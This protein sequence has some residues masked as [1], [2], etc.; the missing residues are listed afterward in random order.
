MTAAF[1]KNAESL[2]LDLL[3]ISGPSGREEEV[4]QFI[5]RQ[6][7]EAGAPEAAIRFDAAPSATGGVRKGDSVRKGDR[8][9]LC[10]APFGPFRQI[11][12]VPFSHAGGETGNLVLRLPGTR[13]D[14]RRLLMAHVDTVPLCQGA[15]PVRRGQY[16]V[17]ADKR[18]ALGAD[19]RAGSAVVLAAATEILRRGLPHP[20]LCFL[21]TVQEEVGLH[22]ARYARLGLL[23]R[24]QLAFNFDGGE[25]QKLT[26][27][28]T[29]GYRMEIHVRGRASHAGVVPE[30]GI[31]AIAIAALAISRL[32]SDGWHGRIE[33]NGRMGTSNVGVIRGGEATNIVTPEVELRAEARSHDPVF[34]RRIVRAIEQAFDQAARAVRN[35]EGDCGE[36][37][38][39][40]HLDYEA[41]RLADDEPCVLAAEEAV[42][43]CVGTPL[44]AIS[45]GGLD[46]NWMT[47]RGIPTVTLG[48]GQENVHTTAE[49][50]NLPEFRRACQ[51]A[52]R[53]ATDAV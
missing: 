12:P 4:M 2:V 22:G 19:D 48:C 44:R 13:R 45:N 9:N 7:R 10:A 17:P 5:A 46:A 33:K 21:W 20:P 42:R 18:T 27:G 28:A 26:V 23:G 37:E 39:D 50:L 16:I 31:S 51:V 40:G 41:F 14:K 34:R 11:G 36:V 15:R 8:S 25:A 1:L 6:L 47:A 53:L 52:L 49:R 30:K 32:H 29:G 38:I 3:A 24:P 43:H 35:V